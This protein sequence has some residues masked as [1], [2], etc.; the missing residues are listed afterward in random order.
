[1]SNITRVLNNG[2]KIPWIGFGTGTAMYKQPAEDAVTLA[3]NSG[4]THI[5]GAQLYGNEVRFMAGATTYM[6]LSSIS[7][8]GQHGCCYQKVP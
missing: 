6:L 1:M 8:I 2:A 5:D 3:I 7:S 4:F